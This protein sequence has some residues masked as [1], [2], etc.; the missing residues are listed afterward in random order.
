MMCKNK[1]TLTYILEEHIER[2]IKKGKQN[3][4]NVTL[5]LFSKYERA[6][7]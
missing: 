2:R 7:M 5:K 1:A 3:D 6:Y 4:K